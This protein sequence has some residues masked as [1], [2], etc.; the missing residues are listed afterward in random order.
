MQLPELVHIALPL[1]KP[2]STDIQAGPFLQEPTS[3]TVSNMFQLKHPSLSPPQLLHSPR[4]PWPSSETLEPQ[5]PRCGTRVNE[6]CWG[7]GRRTFN[8]TLPMAAVPVPLHTAPQTSWYRV[9]RWPEKQPPLYPTL[10]M[11]SPHKMNPT[12]PSSPTLWH[13]GITNTSCSTRQSLVYH[14]RNLPLRR[15]EEL[16]IYSAWCTRD[17]NVTGDVGKHWQM[18]QNV[19]LILEACWNQNILSNSVTSTD[20]NMLCG[21]SVVL[22]NI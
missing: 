20:R 4:L 1:P 8:T 14:E 7:W 22:L 16:Y 12:H 5:N 17:Y 15:D 3:H 9:S 18:W 6:Q 13:R 19:E 2:V 10:L 11:G 21:L